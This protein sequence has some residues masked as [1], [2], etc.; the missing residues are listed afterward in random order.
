MLLV[1]D[2]RTGFTGGVEIAPEWLGNAQDSMHW[3]DSHYKVEG[4]AVAQMQAVFMDNWI[5][6]S[7]EV[8]HGERYFPQIPA[9][10]PGR[11]HI[12]SSSPSGTAKP[13]A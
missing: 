9:V 3:R 6:A 5:K 4:P 7:G 11:A 8:P 2:G 12:F 1:T 10:G 13:C